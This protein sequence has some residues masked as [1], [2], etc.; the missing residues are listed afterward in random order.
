[1]QAKQLR[2]DYSVNFPSCQY[3]LVLPK[4]LGIRCGQILDPGLPSLCIEHLAGRHG[5]AS[6]H[7]SNYATVC[8]PAHR[9][10][11]GN[12][13]ES[14]VAIWWFKHDLARTTGDSRHFDL[15]AIRSAFGRHLPGWLELK[16]ESE[17]LPE[18]ADAM[19]RELLESL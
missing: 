18:W 13:V 19:A 6:E 17:C 4:E 1:M 2:A 5:P 12:E 16:V 14:R 7:W 11:H 15:E 10:K 8:Q 3:C 9:F